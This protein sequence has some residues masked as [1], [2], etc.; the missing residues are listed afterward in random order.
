MLAIMLRFTRCRICCSVKSRLYCLFIFHPWIRYSSPAAVWDMKRH[1]TPVYMP[2]FLRSHHHL[3]ASR[4]TPRMDTRSP[5]KHALLR[6]LNPVWQ[7]TCVLFRTHAIT[8]FHS[9]A[10][11][12]GG[13][14]QEW[15]RWL[16]FPFAPIFCDGK[17]YSPPWQITIKSIWKEQECRKQN[18]RW[19]G[20]RPSVTLP[21]NIILNKEDQHDAGCISLM[22]ADPLCTSMLKWDYLRPDCWTLLLSA[23]LPASTCS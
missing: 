17:N 4:K 6:L 5:P 20:G 13:I 1:A 15:Q 22:S 18:I 2:T 14:S 23:K 9:D 16:F 12:S 7:R 11:H 3:H 19:G 8:F 21:H 10:I